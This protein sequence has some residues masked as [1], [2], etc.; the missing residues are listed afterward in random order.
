[1]SPLAVPFPRRTVAVLGLG[2]IGAAIAG[3]L[4][5]AGHHDVVGCARDR[6]DRLVLE[7]PEGTV[8]VCLRTLADPAEAQPVD[9]VL[10]CTKAHQT[11]SVAPWLARLCQASTRVAVLQNGIGHAARVAPYIGAASA[12]PAVVYYNGERP[13]PGR[14]RLRRG[15]DLDLAVADDALG[16]EFASLLDGTLMRVRLSA[17]FTTRLWRKLLVNAVAN[18]M[19]A[20]TL[21]RQG[22]MRRDDVHAL[23]LAVLEEAAVVGRAEGAR[24]AEDEPARIMDGL[25]SFPP[26]AGTSM[27]FDRLAGRA[28]EIDALTGAIVAAADRHGIAVPLNRALFAL[29]RAVSDAAAR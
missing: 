2:N 8:E 21:Q 11:P 9:W 6:L 25:F 18:P 24:L 13:G 4:C 14:V 22:V 17:D 10:L 20:L 1:M 27:Y 26:D 23:C 15:G 19:T 28:L 3:S 16:R 7:R 29:L 5:A 12:V